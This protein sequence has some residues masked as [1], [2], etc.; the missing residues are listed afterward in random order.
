MSEARPIC[1]LGMHRSGTS[2]LTG[3]LEDAGVHLGGVSKKNPF[4]LKGNQENKLIMDLHDEV[5][6][7]NGGSWDKPPTGEV[8]W[9]ATQKS[10]LAEIIDQY[11]DLTPWAF[12]DPRTLFTLAGWRDFIPEMSC[13]GTFRHPSVVAQS[14][15]RRGKMSPEKGFELWL[16]YNQ[17]LLLRKQQLSFDIVCF[18][19]APD[20]YLQSVGEMFRKL[21]LEIVNTD[22]AFFDEQLRS[23]EVSPMFENPPIEV[24]D[25]YARLRDQSL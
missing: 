22:L 19:L 8:T 23:V 24:M 25:M 15:H 17:K 4:N 10:K 20:V 7:A 9:S 21:N 16:R 5:L 3:L 13:I 14:L 11:R 18:D 6:A 12:K 2:C 1:V